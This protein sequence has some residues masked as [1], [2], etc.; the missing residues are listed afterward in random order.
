MTIRVS[1]VMIVVNGEPFIYYQ[2]ASVYP[3]AH[4]I[5]IVEGATENF[6][7]M[8]T[9]D[10]HSTDRT[11][12]VIA[13]FP[14]PECKIKLVR[15]NGVW[16]EKVDMCNAL[17]PLVTG[18]IIWQIDV[19]EF[20]HPWVHEYIAHLFDEDKELDRIS[21]RVR[22]FFTSLCYEVVGAIHIL[23]LSDVRRVHR[24]TKGDRWLSHRPPT[25]VNTG[26]NPKTIRKE[27]MAQ[28]MFKK[29]IYIFH[30]T[31]LFEKQTRDKSAYYHRMWQDS[32]EEP[33]R[34]MDENWRNFKNPL[35]LSG[36]GGYAA[37]IERFSEPLP[38]ALEQMMANIE[39]G[40]YSQYTLRD[41]TDIEHYLASPRYHQDVRLGKTLNSLYTSVGERNYLG[42][43]RK[44]LLIIL[45]YLRFP[46]R[47]TNRYCFLGVL[48]F[49]YIYIKGYHLIPKGSRWLK[50]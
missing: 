8:T 20:Y 32:H 22:D 23:G 38:P 5:V 12:E 1:Y 37:W 33:S 39:S 13:S 25:L 28:E 42:I 45:A 16:P 6:A 9:V 18:D 26:G 11:L 49:L 4:E 27:I 14:D 19:D 3:Y 2:L 34:W 40:K 50:D 21:F 41:T 24:F 17:M 30:A 31:T 46:N 36:I 43:L 15:R 35:N 7:D 29:D 47:A 48:R 10:G 44:M